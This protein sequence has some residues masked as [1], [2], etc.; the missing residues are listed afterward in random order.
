MKKAKVYVKF[1]KAG[2][3]NM[4]LTW[5]RAYVFATLNGL[6]MHTS[7]WSRIHFGAWLRRERKKRLY[8]GYFK[9]GGLLKSF[10]F[11]Y[12]LTNRRKIFEP[13]VQVINVSN[14]DVV[15]VFDKIFTEYDFFKEIRPY[16]TLIED[17][18]FNMLTPHL[19]RQYE[20]FKQ[21]I[22]GIHIRRGDFLIGSTLT[23]M[24]FFIE[25]VKRVRE[26]A[27]S[28]LEVT[29]FT[30]AKPEEVK[31]LASLKN[32]RIAEPKA[33]ILDMLLL[34]RSQILVLSIGSTFSYW[35]AFL[36]KGKII[37]HPDEWH[38]P[39]DDSDS[40]RE[41]IWDGKISFNLG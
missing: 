36:S 26:I 24:S 7:S 16:R 33:D 3:G 38:V 13:P 2:L 41:N 21:P 40:C 19:R 6:E 34:A 9:Q 28:D 20:Q 22:I 1:P 8:F 32:V 35:A 39:F 18:I 30:D 25:V 17:A 11:L 29:L 23:E 10:R 37:K 14:A 12:Y 15:F 27:G 31:E 4:L 5:S